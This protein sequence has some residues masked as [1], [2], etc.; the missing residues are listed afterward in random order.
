MTA[1]LRALAFDAVRRA[2]DE[3]GSRKLQ[4]V[5]LLRNDVGDG[6]RLAEL[7]A[8]VDWALARPPA[9]ELPEGSVVA[10]S[11]QVW[12][13]RRDNR[14]GHQIEPRWDGSFSGTTHD[15]HIDEML[16]TGAQVL[17]VGTGKDT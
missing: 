13:A 6:H 12:I 3:P 8:A 2:P 10:T 11:D 9:S 17:R 14:C 7:V 15:R 16:T 1:D 5:R 4:A